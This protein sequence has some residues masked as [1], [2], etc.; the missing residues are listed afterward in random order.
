M[1][2]TRTAIIYAVLAAFCYGI[3]SVAAKLLLSEVPLF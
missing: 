2:K 1:E 3:S